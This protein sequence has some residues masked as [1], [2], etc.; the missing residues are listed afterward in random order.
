[1]IEEAAEEVATLML[2]AVQEESEQ[3]F[4]ATDPASAH[5]VTFTAAQFTNDYEVKV[6]AHST[7]PIFIEDRKHDAA[8]LLEAHVID[9]ETFLDLYDPPNLQDLKERLKVIERKEAAAQQAQAQA[10]ATKG[11]K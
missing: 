3:R 7:S 11:K 1:M 9:R 4:Q 10:E 5:K 2:R 8:S 6:D